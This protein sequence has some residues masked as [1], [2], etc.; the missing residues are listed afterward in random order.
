MSLIKSFPFCTKTFD[1]KRRRYFYKKA[2]PFF[3]YS[4]A[5]SISLFTATLTSLFISLETQKG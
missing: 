5:I 2:S 4:H 1:V 3:D